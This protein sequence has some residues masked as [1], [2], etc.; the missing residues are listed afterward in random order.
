MS[1]VLIQNTIS[2]TMSSFKPMI[3]LPRLSSLA[4]YSENSGLS[5]QPG[6]VLSDALLLDDDD[7]P[8]LSLDKQDLCLP[9]G[10]CFVSDGDDRAGRGDEEIITVPK[11]R[12]GEAE[13]ALEQWQSS[14]FP[15]LTEE[16]VDSIFRRN[17]PIFSCT[18][19][20]Y[21]NPHKSTTTSQPI[22]ELKRRLYLLNIP[23]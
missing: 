9:L 19:T 5:S 17:Y 4:F 11:D 10:F 13:S 8:A 3:H 1:A 12:N 16:L 22:Y 21:P 2:R 6:V 20:S 23:C 18:A 14:A 15:L 7:L